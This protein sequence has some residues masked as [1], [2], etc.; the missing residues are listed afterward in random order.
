MIIQTEDCKYQEQ[1]GLS[2]RRQCQVLTER[3]TVVS[4]LTMMMTIDCPVLSND[5]GF[6]TDPSIALHS[7]DTPRRILRSLYRSIS[8]KGGV[9]PSTAR[10]WENKHFIVKR[11]NYDN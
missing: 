10:I 11:K 5:N 1:A 8:F 7:S 3:A 2:N 9:C 4:N 6:T